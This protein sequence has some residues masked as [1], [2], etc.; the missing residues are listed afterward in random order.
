VRDSI[1]N[2]Q[3]SQLELEWTTLAYAFYLP[4]IRKWTNRFGEE[5][6][7][8]DVAHELLRRPLRTASCGGT[9]I[10]IGLSAL[11]LADEQHTILDKSVRTEIDH[12]LNSSLSFLSQRQ[13]PAGMWTLGDVYEMPVATTSKNRIVDSNMMENLASQQM[14]TAH[15][16][17]WLNALPKHFEVPNTMRTRAIDWLKK[18]ITR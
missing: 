12:H 16:V 11:L 4:P 7:F 5:T 6:T 1:A 10:L 17:L 14:V 9:H 15:I 2:F 18:S 13:Q 8:N 3:L